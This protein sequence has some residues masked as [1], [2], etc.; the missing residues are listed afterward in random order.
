MQPKHTYY[1]DVRIPES[2][3]LGLLCEKKQPDYFPA[4]RSD[5]CSYTQ[6]FMC[7]NGDSLS[8]KRGTGNMVAEGGNVSSSRGIGEHFFSSRAGV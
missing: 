4:P 2:Y 7:D 3:P 1:M 6:L 5:L 8:Y